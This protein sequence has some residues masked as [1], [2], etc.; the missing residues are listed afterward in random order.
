[1]LHILHDIQGYRKLAARWIRHEIYEVQQWH[2]Y[3]DVQA[4]LDRY[5]REGDDFPGQ[6]V[7][8]DETWAR[9]YVPNLKRQSNEWKHPGSPGPKKVRPTQ[10]AVKV[11]FTVVYDI[12]EVILQ[13]A[14]P[15]RQTVKRCL[16]LYVPAAP[17][18]STTQEITTTLGGTEPHHSS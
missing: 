15:P 13:E 2:R 18:S 17:H 14:V 8:M 7:A 6:I 16:L 5:K 3:A 11:M 12:D 10:C 9:S 1:M 4:L